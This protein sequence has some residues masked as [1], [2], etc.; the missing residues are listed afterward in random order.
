MKLKTNDSSNGGY[1]ATAAFT[2][3]NEELINILPSDLKKVIVSTRVIS[4]HNG[5]ESL[6]YIN[7][8]QKL[9]L[10]SGVEVYGSDPDDTAA[11]I[12]TQLDYYRNNN[13]NREN[14]INYTIK[15]YNS[16]NWRWWLRTANCNDY[17]YKGVSK[18]GYLRSYNPN[19]SDRG[20][21]APAFRIA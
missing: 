1:P 13:V 10:L 20:G 14:N 6:N 3:L 7:N 19:T 21:I 11:S 15:Y 8:K 12:T 16:E 4:G 2:Y 5:M 17:G 18:D 9:Y